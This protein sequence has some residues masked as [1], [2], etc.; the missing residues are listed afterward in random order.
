MEYY[1][2]HVYVHKLYNVTLETKTL[3]ILPERLPRKDKKNGS[4]ISTAFEGKSKESN[5][6][7]TS[8]AKP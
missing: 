2:T 3:A 7:T 5:D 1:I 8:E 4:K 6:S